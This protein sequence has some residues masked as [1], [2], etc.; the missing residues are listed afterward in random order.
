MKPSQNG[1]GRSNIVT[2]VGWNGVN[3]IFA[4]QATTADSRR[5]PSEP[6][7]IC[8]GRPSPSRCETF[9]PPR[10]SRS[11][12]AAPAPSVWFD[13]CFRQPHRFGVGERLI[14]FRQRI[15]LRADRA[16]RNRA[17]MTL[18][19]PQRAD[20]VRDLTPPAAANLEVLAVDLLVNVDGARTGIRI[21][22]GNHIPSAV[23]NDIE[24]LLAS[25]RRS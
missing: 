1:L 2:D 20:E 10:A 8:S 14:E 13:K 21:V 6:S 9:R 4:K 7:T 24:R 12:T 15:G 11:A 5:N 19:N 18:E 25:A 16:P 22:A 3:T 17:V 23:A